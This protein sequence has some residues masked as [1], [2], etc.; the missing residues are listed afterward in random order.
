MLIIL[1]RNYINTDTLR[2]MFVSVGRTQLQYVH[3]EKKMKQGHIAA[4]K[5]V[6]RP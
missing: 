3:T 6:N 1:G 5:F 4:T 2:N